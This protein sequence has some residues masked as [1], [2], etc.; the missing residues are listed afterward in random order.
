[1]W[2]GSGGRGY[3]YLWRLYLG[4][5]NYIYTYKDPY[6]PPTPLPPPPP[7]DPRRNLPIWWHSAKAK[8]ILVDFES[9]DAWDSLALSPRKHDKYSPNPTFSQDN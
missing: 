8:I 5:A 7:P 1:M 9:R 6:T 4:R 3:V 2:V